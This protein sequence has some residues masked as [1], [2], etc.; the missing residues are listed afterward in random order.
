MQKE[1]Y[2]G[3]ILAFSYGSNYIR[4]NVLL[5]K[6][7]N[8]IFV[9]KAFLRKNILQYLYFTVSKNWTVQESNIAE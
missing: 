6:K 7:M 9:E 2:I 5:I 8:L 3:T 4:S 1:S